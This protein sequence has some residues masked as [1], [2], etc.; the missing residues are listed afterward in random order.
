LCLPS[1]PTSEIKFHLTG[2]KKI[3]TLK[4]ESP[5][6][7]KAYEAA[8]NAHEGQKRVSGEP[9]FNHCLATAQNLLDWGLDEPTIAA[10]L[11]H[12]IVEDT[13]VTEEEI[14]KQFG[15]EISFLVNGVTKLGHI[16]YRGREVQAETL[17]KMI[18]AMAEDLRVVLIK[19]ADRK[20]NM[21]TLKV[22]PPQKQKRIAQETMEIYS[23]LAYRLGMQKLSGELEDIAFPY[24][25]PQEYR[26][27][28]ENVADRYEQREKYLRKIQPVVERALKEAGVTA[29]TVDFR[30]KRYAS[31][32]K[33]L[34]RYDMD[35]DKIHDL[36]AFRLVLKTIE[37][38]YAA[39]GVIH[40][41]WP[42]I[43]GR[44]KDY[45]AMPKPNGY[46][47]LHTTILCEGQ[48]IVEFQIRNKEMHDEAENGI[49]AHWAY[50]QMKGGKDY[51]R[52]RAAR[53]ET[54]EMAWVEQ[55]RAWQNEFSDS[56]EFI[57]SLKIDFFKDRIFVITPKGEVIDLPQGATPIDFAYSIHTDVGNQCVGAKVNGKIVPLDYKLHSQDLVEV[58]TQKGKK[59]SSAWLEIAA[60]GSAKSKI[61][62]ALREKKG[63]LHDIKK[64]TEFKIT[65]DDDIGVLK[66]VAD[67][68]S[69]SHVNILT[70]NSSQ[71]K[72]GRF[73]M[74]K[75]KCNTDDREKVMKIMLKLK[76]IKAV[77]EIEYR[78]V[79]MGS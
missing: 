11:L 25:Y 34:L 36:V 5:L 3:E 35:L 51:A 73:H 47:S 18:L 13:K 22:L 19:L 15:E 42:P 66:D 56:K 29:T 1:K 38:C 33:K 52:R 2:M 76:G 55:L 27:L 59:P 49:A 60:T 26:W 24:I 48:K 74:M 53:A 57:D 70:I 45:I 77:R 65:A 78:F 30:A 79:Q 37:D 7:A 39:L 63:I 68:I 10:G 17:R 40:K 12:D 41:L 16:K 69:R 44:I 21:Q 62:S 32:Y 31:L 64:A 14:Q 8:K 50:E 71:E 6:I 61:K 72:R 75:I 67:V 23:P 46:R 28:I 43:P 58:I 20:H 54:K 9:Y 4:N